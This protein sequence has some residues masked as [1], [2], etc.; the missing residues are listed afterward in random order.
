[1]A[2]GIIGVSGGRPRPSG[3]MVH[4]AILV[5]KNAITP[6]CII[7][8]TNSIISCPFSPEY[9]HSPM[10]NLSV[11]LLLV[12]DKQ[13]D[14]WIKSPKINVPL[15]AIC[16]A[17]SGDKGDSA[18]IGVVARDP[19]FYHY[20]D[21]I[22]TEDAIA[23]FIRHLLSPHSVVK[24]YHLPGIFAFNFF[25]TKCLGGGGLSSLQIDRQGKTYAQLLLNMK[26]MVPKLWIAD[27]GSKL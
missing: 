6:R 13:L 19:R 24:K 18:N 21:L 26:V 27:S 16:I 11:P 10:I 9:F 22:L 7:G 3:N 14:R 20:L 8:R 4:F 23:K 2:P 1:M 5:E 15:I 25:V 17:R 12:E